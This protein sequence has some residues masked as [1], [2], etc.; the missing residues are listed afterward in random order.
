MPGSYSIQTVDDLAKKVV[1]LI[2]CTSGDVVIPLPTSAAAVRYAP[3]Y[4]TRTDSTS[5]RAVVTS[6]GVV[7]LTLD[8]MNDSAQVM[9]NGTRYWVISAPNLTNDAAVGSS[10]WRPNEELL[11]CEQDFNQDWTTG[12]GSTSFVTLPIARVQTPWLKGPGVIHWDISGIFYAAGAGLSY[13]WEFMVDGAGSGVTFT[14]GPLAAATAGP[15]WPWFNFQ[16][17]LKN[18]PDSQQGGNYLHVLETVISIYKHDDTKVLSDTW[19]RKR[20][21]L[22]PY[23]AH[24][25]GWRFQH[26]ANTG[27]YNTLAK[28]VLCRRLMGRTGA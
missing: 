14:H 11:T 5:N 19:L 25:F 16:A 23:T 18:I 28:S 27:G 9:W 8:G 1:Y 22:N 3:I 24:E 15:P 21:T 7:L 26:T 20:I 12:D 6:N 10:D 4:L 2:D 13:L 17:Y